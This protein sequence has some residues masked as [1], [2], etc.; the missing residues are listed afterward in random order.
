MRQYESIDLSF[1]STT[2]HS[3]SAEVELDCSPE[4]LF[5]VFEDPDSWAE[6]VDAITGVEWT[7]PK[8]YRVGTTRTVT[9]LG[10]QV[11]N[12]EFIAWDR[13][14]HMAFKFVSGT[15]PVDAFGENYEVTDL[16][17][18]RCKLRWTLAL[19]QSGPMRL[20]LII[21]APAMRW[22]V[23]RTLGGLKRYIAR[24]QFSSAEPIAAQ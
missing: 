4:Q 13:G 5:D 16:G 23:R 9:L 3:F 19:K 21:F 1:M 10:R 20:T 8:P 14:K 24:Q 6:W 17:G 15:M 12:E 2:P 22:V 7:S 18:G 11:A